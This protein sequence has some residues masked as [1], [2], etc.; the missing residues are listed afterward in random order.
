M[1]EEYRE[2]TEEQFKVT[3][4]AGRYA[5]EVT[6]EWNVVTEYFLRLDKPNHYYVIGKMTE[7]VSLSPLERKKKWFLNTQYFVEE[8]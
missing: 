4:C 5:I 2:V 6:H 8:E 3:A 1:N 7:I